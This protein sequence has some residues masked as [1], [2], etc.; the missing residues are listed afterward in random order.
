MAH[1]A[2]YPKMSDSSSDWELPKAVLKKPHLGRPPAG[3]KSAKKSTKDSYDWMWEG[4]DTDASRALDTATSRKSWWVVMEK[5]HGANFAFRTS[6]LNG[7]EEKQDAVIEVK[8]AKRRDFLDEQ[9]FFGFQRVLEK[10]EDRIKRI[11]QEL[12]F[13]D[14]ELRHLN[15][16]SSDKDCS[17]LTIYGE[18]F[19]GFY[20]V[21]SE[22]EVS[23]VDPVQKEILYSP[24]PQ[25]Y[26]FDI[27][28]HEEGSDETDLKNYMDYDFCMCVF[29]KFGL[30]SAK[31]LFVGSFSD[32]IN[33][34]LEFRSTIPKRLRLPEISGPNTA[35]GIVVKPFKN[36]VLNNG[37][38]EA[39]V[40]FKKKNKTFL[41]DVEADYDATV[42]AK[43]ENKEQFADS[44]S[45]LNLINKNRLA[46]VI[47]KEGSN[48]AAERLVT[49]LVQDAITDAE[50]KWT[51]LSSED[52]DKVREQMT[53][54]AENLVKRK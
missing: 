5:V 50:T 44:T 32:A 6:V 22:Q 20:P 43:L 23:Q 18:L 39:R 27:L 17:G 33:F 52:Q 19:G 28:V 26:A 46:A 51:R 34:S 29:D 15:P 30:F 41:E 36:L 54:K 24:E 7:S 2:V 45:F 49:A 16:L 14:G 21:Q 8:C 25:F 10:L 31:P 13:H 12:C 53:K 1:H 11:H 42:D 3:G 9:I 47:S 40:I 4:L 38:S 48:C 37:K 35:E